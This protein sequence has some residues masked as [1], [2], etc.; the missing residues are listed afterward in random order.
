[1]IGLLLPA[2]QKVREAAARSS[3]QN[4]L[5]QMSLAIINCSDTNQQLMPP[6]LG[7]YP[8]RTPSTNNG[9]G[10][11]FFHILPYIEQDN[12]Y[13]ASLGVDDRNG[14]LQ[15]YTLWNAQN[16]R[17]KIYLCPSDPTQQDKWADSVTSYGFNARIFHI[18]YS[19]GWGVGSKTFP[20]WLADGT[21]QTIMTMEKM[22]RWFAH[23][24]TWA[25]DEDMNF[26]PDWGPAIYSPEATEQLAM[27][28]V[29][30]MFRICKNQNEA[31][32]NRANSP[33][34]AGIQVGLGDGSVRFVSQGINVDTWWAAITP[35]EGDILGSGW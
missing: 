4:N 22:N 15:T 26:W 16:V 6:G 18:S 29:N 19:G 9:Q 2:V 5:K 7:L 3:C 25:P 27:A 23:K 20:A 24:P 13:K 14:N 28:G 17:V 32:G 12:A 31:H 34:T 8:S 35:N 10:G 21:S 33:H 30:S 1:L 11:L